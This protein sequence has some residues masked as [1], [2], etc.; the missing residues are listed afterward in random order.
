M[1]SDAHKTPETDSAVIR[2]EQNKQHPE[3]VSD[4]AGQ[5]DRLADLIFSADERDF[6]PE[7]LDALLGELDVSDPLPVGAIPDPRGSLADFRSRLDGAQDTNPVGPE[8]HSVP[9]KNSCVKTFRK[10]LPIAAILILMIS[11][12]TPTASGNKLFEAL[13]RWTAEVFQLEDNSDNYAMI[14]NR[15]LAEGERKDYDTPEA[16]LE[17]FGIDADLVPA[18][19]PER[20][21]TPEVW[22]KLSDH[23][24]KLYVF[25]ER[26][27][28]FLN[29]TLA[30]QDS[31]ALHS[32][33]K[34]YQDAVRKEL[35]GIRHH[36]IIDLDIT[37]II[38]ENGELECRI[39]GN[40][41][42]EEMDQ[43]LFSIYED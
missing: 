30:E 4:S 16:M 17:D 18:W 43:V 29:I 12:M 9:K 33:E 2:L 25:F 26:E 36:I 42:Q 3:R 8:L 21:G 13:G 27:D 40:L 39:T 20:L 38:W 41:S 22:A 35:D 1:M 23:G 34:D 32:V 15:P 24:V 6:D 7:E 19:V 28:E 11:V 14:R 31:Q 37:K 10:L 5:L